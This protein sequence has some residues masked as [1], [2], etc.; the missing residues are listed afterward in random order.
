MASKLVNPY[1]TTPNPLQGAYDAYSGSVR[2]QAGD[3]DDIMNRYRSL[4]TDIGNNLGPNLRNSIATSGTGGPIVPTYQST[5]DYQNAISNLGGL[6]KTGGYS[7]ADIANIRERGISPIRSVYANAQENLNRQK[8]LQGGYSPNYAA[9]SAKMA[10]EMSSQLADQ[11]TAVNAQLAQNIAQN[12]IAT[13]TPYASITAGEQANRNDFALRAADI[14]NSTKNNNLNAILESYTAPLQGK[15]SA[16]SGMTGLYGTTP[17]FANMLGN[18]ANAQAG[19]Q[20]G[21]Q[22][23]NRSAALNTISQYLH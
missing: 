21:I 3:Y 19:L 12:K 17:A 5:P 20:A 2:Q 10:R 1:A 11:T 6:A 7:D 23:G 13:S 16:L 15:L 22:Q 8:S 18:Q 14:A 9:V 4:L